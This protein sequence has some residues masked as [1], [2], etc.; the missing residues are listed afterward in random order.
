MVFVGEL[1]CSAGEMNPG[2]CNSSWFADIAFRGDGV[3]IG[4]LSP[5]KDIVCERKIDSRTADKR[6]SSRSVGVHTAS[7]YKLAGSEIPQTASG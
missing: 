7:L 5:Y 3:L 2:A 4:L 6:R 1:S